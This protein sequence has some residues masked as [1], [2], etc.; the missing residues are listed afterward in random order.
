MITPEMI[1]E[2]IITRQ[3]SKLI[4]LK[5]KKQFKSKERRDVINMLADFTFDRLEINN[6]KTRLMTVSA[7]VV[8]FPALMFNKSGDKT[9][10]S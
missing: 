3:K 4:E 2:Y 7:A 6:N 9:F 1:K 10:V 8:L 5:D